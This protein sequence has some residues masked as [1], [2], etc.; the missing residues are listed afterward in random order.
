[1]RQRSR[2]GWLLSAGRAGARPVPPAGRSRR[3]RERRFPRST[4]LALTTALW[5]L[6]WTFVL[7]SGTVR[8]MQIF[9]REDSGPARIL[10]VE[11]SDTVAQVKAGIEAET[12]ID[13]SRQR[14]YF[15]N[16]ELDDSR[17]LSDY[18]IQK[19]ATLRLVVL[20][21]VASLTLDAVRYTLVPGG[22]HQTIVTAVYSDGTERDVTSFSTFA[23]GDPAVASVDAN[24]LVTAHAAGTTVVTATYASFTAQATVTVRWPGSGAST[25]PSGGS[26]GTASEASGGAPPAAPPFPDVS[27]D[28]WALGDIG[29]LALRGVASGFPDG[30]FRASQPVTRAEFVKLLLLAMGIEPSPGAAGAGGAGFADVPADAWFA[31]YVG[32]AL[33]AGIVSGRAPGVFA[34]EAAL[35]R[36][37]AAVLLARALHL[38]PATDV[39]FTDAGET[40][41]W[42]RT[43][44]A[45]VAEAG[46]MR[47]YPDGTFRPRAPMTRA[48]AAAVLARILAR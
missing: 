8:A 39:P 7:P 1:M 26:D 25:P 28:D 14:L 20:P 23:S 6:A 22:T 9:V 29:E 40:D 45:A 32:A 3:G 44:V 10:E 4:G 15:H 34:P 2:Q 48:E 42:A 43:S 21:G 17:T 38:P 24:G 5:L 31:G 16:Q 12:G 46:Y 13:A 33:Q 36:E 19:E 11:P 35:S 41:E 27:S 47:G 37:E 18:N 30:T